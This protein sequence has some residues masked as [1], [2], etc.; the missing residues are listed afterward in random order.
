MLI[1]IQFLDQRPEKLNYIFIR[2]IIIKIHLFLFMGNSSSHGQTK[3]KQKKKAKN[4]T[5]ASIS[6]RVVDPK[7]IDLPT[8]LPTDH[9]PDTEVRKISLNTIMVN[10]FAKLYSD[11]DIDDVPKVISEN[12]NYIK[13]HTIVRINDMNSLE[14]IKKYI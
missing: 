3:S 11:R 2:I 12:N 1:Y 4:I 7:P 10:S 14:Q 8:D 6:S 13:N 9:D 5:I